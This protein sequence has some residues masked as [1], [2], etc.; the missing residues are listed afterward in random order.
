MATEYNIT[1]KQYNGTDYDTLYPQT[2]SQQVLLN[3]DAISYSDNPT[4]NGA[5]IKQQ[6]DISALNG[7]TLGIRGQIG[8]LT[9]WNID[10]M[11]ANESYGVWWLNNSDS[12][13]TGT[14]PVSSGQGV[15]F[16]ERQTSGIT[17]QLYLGV[18]AS[19]KKVR[20]Y[21]HS[22]GAWTAWEDC[23]GTP[24][25]A[26]WTG[27][28]SGQGNLSHNFGANVIVLSAWTNTSD[29]V[30]M[31]YPSGGTTTGGSASWWFHVRAATSA[32]AVVT[33]SVTITACYILV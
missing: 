4:V 5:L 1:Q 23:P 20:Y 15:L 26:S 22:T 16:C 12:D 9:S 2:T 3:D 33:S 10:Q 7:K 13:M 24:L 32:H 19:V 31:P 8:A 30:V 17:R 6:E 25:T 11:A 29:T 21:T 27:T 14:K 28:P 18:T